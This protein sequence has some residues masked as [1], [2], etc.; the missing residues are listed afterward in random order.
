MKMHTKD[1]F[2]G[3]PDFEFSLTAA[4]DSGTLNYNDDLPHSHEGT[5]IY[6]NLSGD[7]CFIVNDRLY[8]IERGSALIIP[9]GVIHHC[10][11]EDRRREHDH[12]WIIATV[13]V[14]DP[15]GKR[16]FGGSG[17]TVSLKL[18]E[19]E[20]KRIDKSLFALFGMCDEPFKREAAVLE[21]FGILSSA[22]KKVSAAA[23]RMLP[24]DI[25]YAIGYISQNY[26]LR[27][28]VSEIAENA[29]VSVN[30]LER[31]FNEFLRKTP[32]QFLKEYRLCEAA[33]LLRDGKTVSEACYASGFSDCSHF[34]SDFYSM[35]GETPLKYKKISA[36]SKDGPK[37]TKDAVR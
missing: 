25:M 11:Y 32:R 4:R 19:A 8:P 10:V 29:R 3:L 13:K 17:S 7:V 9:P 5:E 35:F 12:I 21:F 28:T 30:T 31:H 22:V 14:D 26:N 33:V 37:H 1:R 6:V 34:I 27:I 15:I 23:E 18:S 24:S 16:L 36:E 20:L 2:C